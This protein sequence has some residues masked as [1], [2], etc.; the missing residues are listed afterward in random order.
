MSVFS[1]TI[2]F[3]YNKPWLWELSISYGGQFFFGFLHESCILTTF[4]EKIFFFDQHFS[5]EK[6]FLRKTNFTGQIWT[7]EFHIE[8]SSRRAQLPLRK[9]ILARQVGH[10]AAS[11]PNQKHELQSLSCIRN[12]YE[13]E[14]IS[15]ISFSDYIKANINLK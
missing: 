10:E 1:V 6:H 15:S 8:I 3:H 13:Y 11:P 7:D 5:I 12:V 9:E 14:L 4:G 2:R